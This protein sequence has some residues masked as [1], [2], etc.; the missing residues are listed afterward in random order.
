MRRLAVLVMA[1][2]AACGGDDDGGDG[3]LPDADIA[4]LVYEACPRDQY[5]G[6]FLAA[7]KIDYSS[8]EGQ[9]KDRVTPT[10][11]TIYDVLETVGECQL[12]KAPTYQCTPACGG[13][14][15]C[16]AQLECVPYAAPRSVGD[17]SVVGLA[18]PVTMPPRMPNY[19]YTFT[20]TLPHPAFTPGAA[21]QMSTS[22]GDYSPFTLRG[23]GVGPV[24]GAP[25]Q[26]TVES[27][28]PLALTWTPPAVPGPIKMEIDLNING[29]GVVGAHVECVVDDDGEY[30][31]PA[32]LI[33]SLVG[34]GMSGFPTLVLTRAS[35]DSTTIEPGCVDF[36]VWSEKIIEVLIPGLSSCRDDMDCPM[37]QTC[38][39]DL[40]CA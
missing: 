9:V 35:S 16:T 37:G 4:D 36:R 29:H 2:L 19:Y 14:E 13:G 8:V 34:Q 40:T 21:I 6:G 39:T 26:V 12:L 33:T 5:V 27:G 30:T 17:V 15:E 24:E 10:T 23:F 32:E 18:V 25:D 11:T 38:Q 7:L 1:A 28:M 31:I 3:A 22:G 20:G